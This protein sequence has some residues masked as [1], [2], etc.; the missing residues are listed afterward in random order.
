M[1]A[2]EIY[3]VFSGYPRP[4]LRDAYPD[5]CSASD[6]VSEKIDEELRRKSLAEL[7]DA[8]LLDYYY[9]AVN[10]VG[11]S[12]DFKFYLPR[13]LELMVT[14]RRPLLSASTLADTLEA[15]EFASWPEVEREAVLAFCR[16]A[17][18]EAKLNRV[19]E[20]LAG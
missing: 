18:A 13:I 4:Q 7:S 1:N 9:L 19:A 20:Q 11:T 14:V 12:E 15:A 16:S 10:H 5:A 2:R 8:D 6:G 17:R 3:A